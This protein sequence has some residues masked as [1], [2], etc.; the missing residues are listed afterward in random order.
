M[1][2]DEL[3]ERLR[4]QEDN[5]VER[6][7]DGLSPAEIRKAASAFANTVEDRSAILFIGVHDKTGDLLG[8]RDTDQMQKKVRAA[9]QEDCYPPIAYTSH[10]LTCDGKSIVAV[11]IP[12][13]SSKPHFTGPAFVRVGSDSLKASQE[14]L[15]ELVLNRVDKCREILRYKGKGLIS[16]RGVGYKLGSNKPVADVHYPQHADCTVRN[17]TAHVVTLEAID[18]AIYSEPLDRIEVSYDTERARPMLVIRFPRG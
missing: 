16:V 15:N 4:D 8:V 1:T 3:L 2:N 6:K 18:G 17:C 5:F 14:Q 13:S 7:S 9:C 11:V 10:V 12:P